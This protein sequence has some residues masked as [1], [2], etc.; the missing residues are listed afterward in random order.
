MN[1]YI[2]FR[3]NHCKLQTCFQA[4]NLFSSITSLK[5]SSYKLVFPQFA[6]LLSLF[7]TEIC[8]T[9]DK[10]KRCLHSSV[11]VHGLLRAT[12]L[13]HEGAS[14]VFPFPGKGGYFISLGTF[15]EKA[16]KT[17]CFCNCQL[18]NTRDRPFPES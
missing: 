14:C 15:P 13:K 7:F 1:L 2:H 17:G 16:Q 11:A 10:Q 3:R 6:Y 5:L 4:T 12:K 18:T 9:H 8:K